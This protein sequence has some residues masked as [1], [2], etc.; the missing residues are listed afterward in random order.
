MRPIV[1]LLIAI[2]LPTQGHAEDSEIASIFSDAGVEGTIVIATLDGSQSYVHNETRAARRFRPL[3]VLRQ[4]LH[5]QA[6]GHLPRLES[7]RNTGAIRTI[8]LLPGPRK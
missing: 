7:E 4:G 6:I 2:A 8:D 5:S 1:T 3:S